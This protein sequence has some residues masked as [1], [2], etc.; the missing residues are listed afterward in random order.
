MEN[1]LKS[2]IMWFELIVKGIAFFSH[3]VSPYSVKFYFESTTSLECRDY[4]KCEL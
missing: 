1:C 2:L 3:S 4:M